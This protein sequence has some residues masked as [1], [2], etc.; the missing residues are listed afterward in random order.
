MASIETIARAAFEAQPFSRFLGAELLHASPGKVRIRLKTR[1]ELMHQHGQ[2]HGGVLSYLADN[3]L[4]FAGGI[5][6]ESESV[7][8]AE[9]KINYARPA[10]GVALVAEAAPEAVGR[11][12]AVCLCRVLEIDELGEKKLCAIAVGTVARI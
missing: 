7:A 6:L 11:R 2:V 10:N 3:A 1:T 12:Q 5:A 4:T 9:F 8:T